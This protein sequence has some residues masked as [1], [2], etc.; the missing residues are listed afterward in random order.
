MPSTHRVLLILAFVCL[1][2]ASLPL[3]FEAF[4]PP[5][6]AINSIAWACLAGVFLL[7]GMIWPG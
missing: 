5:Q 2:V 3:V 7:A 4:P 1:I 6:R